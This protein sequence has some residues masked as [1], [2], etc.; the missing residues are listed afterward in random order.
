MD[1][2]AYE[3]P[4]H[5]A[6]RPEPQIPWIAYV[7]NVGVMVGGLCLSIIGFQNLV[8]ATTLLGLFLLVVGAIGTFYI[9]TY[10]RRTT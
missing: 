8:S 5:Y 7:A 10:S 3:A 2:N 6:N 1:L 9:V 4:K